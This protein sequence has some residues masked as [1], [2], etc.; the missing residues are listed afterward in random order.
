MP[1]R[2]PLRIAVMDDDFFAL[3]GTISLLSRDL[4]TS[5]EAECE[6]AH[7][8]IKAI[9][10]KRLK[11]HVVLIDAE[12]QP[13]DMSLEDTIKKV[14]KIAPETLVVCWSQYGD[15][16]VMKRAVAAGADSLMVKKDVKLALATHL[17][18]AYTCLLYTSPSPRDL[19]T[20]RMPSSA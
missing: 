3:K 20:S 4:R 12:R 16:D 9:K 6:T 18:H 1:I 15:P 8:L 19:S 11:P 17:I 10:G 5:I 7:C 2:F 14:K 13:S